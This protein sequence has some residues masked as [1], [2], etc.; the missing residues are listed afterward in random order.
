MTTEKWAKKTPTAEE[1]TQVVLTLDAALSNLPLGT[2]FDASGK[3]V[4][5]GIVE[6]KRMTLV[7]MSA[8]YPEAWEKVV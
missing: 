7:L 1:L 4:W 2:M 5:E 3:D 6:A 8:W